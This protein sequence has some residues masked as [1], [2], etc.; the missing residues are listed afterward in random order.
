M[1]RPPGS[2][3]NTYSTFS[4]HQVGNWVVRE[5]PEATPPADAVPATMDTQMSLQNTVNNAIDEPVLA[6]R[7][8]LD[9]A[10]RAGALASDDAHDT[11]AAV[12]ANEEVSEE[13]PDKVLEKIVAAEVHLPPLA[14]APRQSQH[15]AHNHHPHPSPH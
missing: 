4:V 2:Q 12:A 5:Y 11:L 1:P 8:R 6:I 15:G 14:P 7:E 9:N 13:L 10:L 3:V